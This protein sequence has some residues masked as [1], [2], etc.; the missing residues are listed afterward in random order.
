MWYYTNFQG[1]VPHNSIVKAIAELFSLAKEANVDFVDLVTYALEENKD[2]EENTSLSDIPLPQADGTASL[3]KISGLDFIKVESEKLSILPCFFDDIC[4]SY[5][6]DVKDLTQSSDEENEMNFFILGLIAEKVGNQSKAIEYYEKAKNN[7][8]ALRR[9]S[10]LKKMEIKEEMELLLKSIIYGEVEALFDLAIKLD[11]SIEHEKAINLIQKESEN[12]FSNDAK[13]LMIHGVLAM[14]FDEL[15]IDKAISYFEKAAKFN[16]PASFFYLGLIYERGISNI[17]PD[18]KK[19]INYY[20]LAARLDHV[21]SIC[22]LGQLY[23]YGSSLWGYEHGKYLTGKET[24]EIND[25]QA[26]FYYEKIASRQQIFA[27]QRLAWYYLHGFY[28]SSDYA[29]AELYAKKVITLNILC[30]NNSLLTTETTDSHIQDLY[31]LLNLIYYSKSIEKS[32]EYC[33]RAYK[34]GSRHDYTYNSICICWKK[35][36]KSLSNEMKQTYYKRII[37]VCNHVILYENN[38]GYANYMIAKLNV[39]YL[40]KGDISVAKRALN[41]AYS[42]YKDRIS[43]NKDDAPAHYRLARILELSIL[44]SIVEKDQTIIYYQQAANCEAKWHVVRFYKEKAKNKL[45]KLDKIGSKF[46]ESDSS[47]SKNEKIKINPGNEKQSHVMLSY[48][49]ETRETVNLIKNALEK[50]GFKVWIDYQDMKKDIFDD[51]T[52]GV[53]NA[54]HIISCISEYY[55]KSPYC[56]KELLYAIT[57]AKKPVI[58]IIVQD[59]YSPKGWIAFAIAGIKYYRVTDEN[60]LKKVFPNVLELISI[61]AK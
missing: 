36:A 42:Y 47:V 28:T 50:Y 23:D 19:A 33:L 13:A 60:S 5:E 7:A 56:R 55:E 11:T 35:L 34:V 22:R 20:Q 41:E 2:D 15:N 43:T 54:T 21:Y 9:I 24:I 61:Q 29:K 6:N 52:F 3:N 58:P 18:V 51:M 10:K 8:S 57:T 32:Y 45:E 37:D 16:F 25:K 40:L 26:I 59:A 30:S 1:I 53:D 17:E 46:I 44:D 27:L 49:S 38:K 39:K 31:D 14:V 48:A 4:K 12:N